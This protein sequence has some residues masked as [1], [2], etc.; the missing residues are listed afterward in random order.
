MA[1]H[2]TL[3]EVRKRKGLSQELVA[4]ELGISRQAVTKWEAGQSKPSARNL[5]A[6]AE[7][8]QVP[9]EELL[10]GG[11]EEEKLYNPILRANLIKIAII[12]HAGFMNACAQFMYEFR[13]ADYPDKDFYRGLF[14]F[15]LVLLLLASTWMTSNHRFEP[16]MEQRRKN[17]KI[18]LAYCCVQLLIALP[19]IPFGRGLVGIPLV[20]IVTLVYILYIN[21]KFMNRK[22]T[23]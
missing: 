16:D 4:E 19:T 7:L 17:T 15:S 22:L 21:P 2:D 6:L 18:E 1:L 8:Y 10:G 13:S 9:V 12:L 20:L 5:Q 3:K 11:P 23:T 14:L